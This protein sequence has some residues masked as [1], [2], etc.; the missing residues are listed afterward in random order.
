MGHTQHRCLRTK[1]FDN[2]EPCSEEAV[3][4]QD[5]DLG[6]PDAG[7]HLDDVLSRGFESAGAGS[8]QDDLD[9]SNSEDDDGHE[10]SND[11]G[12]SDAE[13]VSGIEL[14]PDADLDDVD[15]FALPVPSDVDSGQSEASGEQD[16][17]TDAHTTAEVSDIEDCSFDEQDFAAAMMSGSDDEVGGVQNVQES[18]SQ[19]ERG[20]K[21]GKAQKRKKSDMDVFADYEQYAHLLD[22]NAGAIYSQNSVLGN[23]L[24]WQDI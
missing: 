2:D 18:A 8:S 23:F 19:H 22:G 7:M 9:Q 10:H 20:G 17:P 4:V 1:R 24:R 13:N 12:E 6:D 15:V 21:R 11:D 5:D 16:T 14:V 3:C